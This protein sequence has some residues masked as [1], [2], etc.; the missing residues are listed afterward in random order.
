MIF[1][2]FFKNI[3]DLMKS[4]EN[5]HCFYYQKVKFLQKI[6]QF[7]DV[8]WKLDLP[9]LSQAAIFIKISSFEDIT[10]KIE[11]PLLL[12]AKIFAKISRI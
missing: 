3:L 4:L 5:S 1:L 9:L 2:N 6:R 8:N 7:V 10:Q 12:Q 11:L